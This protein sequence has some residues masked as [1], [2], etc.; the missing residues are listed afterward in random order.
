MMP[1]TSFRFTA[2]SAKNFTVAHESGLQVTVYFCGD[3]GCHIYKT[4]DRQGFKGVAV[5]QVGTLDE[6]ESLRKAKPDMEL[7]TKYRA[8]WLPQFEGAALKSEF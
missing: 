5:I 8:S 4:G 7:W 2:G 1:E 6:P 3:C